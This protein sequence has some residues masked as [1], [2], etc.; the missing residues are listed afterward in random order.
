VHLVS[1]FLSIS[2]IQTGKFVL[3]TKPTNLADTIQ[4]EIAG[5]ERLAEAH[6]IPVIYKHPKSFPVLN[7]DEDKLRQVVMNFIDN[8]IYYSRNNAK[9]IVVKLHATHDDVFVE[10]HDHGIGVPKD[11]QGQ[12]F[13]KFYRAENA[14]RQ[15]PDGTG[16]GLFLAKKVIVAHGGEVVFETT[17]NLGSVFGFKLPRKKLEVTS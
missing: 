2:R 16:V 8:A 12:L 7:V 10:V 14:Q 13:T 9:P 4:E 3:D 6:G 17:E 11:A 15:R 1:D 5:I